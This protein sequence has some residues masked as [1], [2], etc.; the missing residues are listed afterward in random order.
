MAD[1]GVNYFPLHCVLDEK[2]ELLEAEYG[3]KGF[4][5]VVKLFQR[6]YKE[7]GYYCEW[8]DDIALI[9]ARQCG[10]SSVGSGIQYDDNSVS[11]GT[12]DKSSVSGKT[13]NL[14]NQVVA[15]SI[16]RGIFD[17]RL[18]EECSILTSRGIQRNFL[19]IV[20]NRK[21]VEVKNEYLLL[22]DAEIKGNVVRI[23]NSDVRKVN[24]DVRIKQSKVKE[25][26]VKNKNTLCKADALA[27]FERLWT[28]YPVKKGKGQVSDA[29]KLK[30]LEIGF[31]E[32]VRAIERYKNYVESIDYLQYQNGSTFFNSG[33]VDYLDANYAQDHA[34]E[35]KSR[36]RFNQFQQ[37]N[38]DFD[39]LEKRLLNR[40]GED[41]C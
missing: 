8:N 5:I 29:K 7:H 15:A 12:S 35:S 41:S 34:K 36:N 6:I 25:S 31:D 32:M 40:T 4:A 19:N 30:L 20:R 1:E 3:L 14:I 18:F 21:K 11:L 22:S 2:F 27:L 33:Y 9:F 23:Y 26:K 24:S 37:N 39:R 13:K 16:R 10:L 28:L 38:Y 17:K